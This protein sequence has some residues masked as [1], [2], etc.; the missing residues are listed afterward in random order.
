MPRPGRHI[1]GAK[2]RER[3]LDAASRLIGSQGY[4]AT[5]IA[6]IS[7][8]SGANPASIYWAFENKEALFAAVME[9][10]AESFFAA[11]GSM[12]P[13]PRD[14]WKGLASLFTYFEG[15]PE[16]LR[17][18]LV[19]S[20]ERRDGDPAVLEAARRVRSRAVDGL[21]AA[22]ASAFAFENA[23]QQRRIAHELA[24]LTLM[25]FD[26]AFIAS[27]IEPDST[28]LKRAFQLI[29]MSV[30][31]TGERLLEEAAPGATPAGGGR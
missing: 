22:Y 28:N 4:A 17:L 19:L 10:A 26:G 15:G 18:M 30:K 14:P 2:T 9:R 5:S 31:A 3:V 16:F 25:L 7:E 27:Q 6:R 21:A 13:E 12:R 8:A 20:L 1:E 11:V 29:A 24:R 23:R